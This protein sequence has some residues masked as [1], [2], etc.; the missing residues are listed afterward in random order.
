MAS[1][2]GGW[3]GLSEGIGSRKRTL[4]DDLTFFRLRPDR[5]RLSRF[6]TC[7]PIC[8]DHPYPFI[9]INTNRPSASQMAMSNPAPQLIYN[10]LFKRNSVYVSA[11]F[12]SAFGFSMGFDLATSAFWDA[13]NRGV[14]LLSGSANDQQPLTV[15]AETMEGH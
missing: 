1:V 14:S 9:L 5:L 6:T 3:E 10:T 2:S 15:P 12:L 11:I 4:A 7:E 8:C 13:R